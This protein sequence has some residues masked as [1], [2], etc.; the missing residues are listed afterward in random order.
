MVEVRISEI[1][2]KQLDNGRFEVEFDD[3]S[4]GI[5]MRKG[6]LEENKKET[7]INLMLS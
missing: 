2:G 1:R 6:E 3:G 4:K 7:I 5:L